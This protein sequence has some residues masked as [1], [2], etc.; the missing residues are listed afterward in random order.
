MNCI[1]DIL[2]NFVLTTAVL[3]WFIAQVLKVIQ[4]LILE[5]RICFSRF[6][7]SG[8]MP[9]SHSS[10]VTSLATSVGL[11]AGFDSVEFAISVAFALV[12]MYDAS[13]IRRAAGEQAKILNR[14]IEE[15]Q[16]GN[17]QNTNIKL[18]ELLGH[19]PLEVVA[20]ALLGIIIAIVRYN[21]I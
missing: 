12:V 3:S 1:N 4:V 14:I 16:S 6:T 17:Y 9:S 19:T 21:F 20:G 2:G 7:G 11:I 5:R 8:G 10:T 18:K 13:G 15:W